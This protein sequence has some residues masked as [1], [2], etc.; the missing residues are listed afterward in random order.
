MAG[1]QTFRD[2]LKQYVDDDSLLGDLAKD[3]F[4]PR[5]SWQ[6]ESASSLY[7]NM[8]QHSACYEAYE[9]LSEARKM[10]LQQRINP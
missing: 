4:N 7:Q 6:G 2:W 10:Y 1:K 5:S 8:K 3:V 9:A